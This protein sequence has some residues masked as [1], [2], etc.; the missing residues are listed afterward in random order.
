MGG[1]S[2]LPMNT[3]IPLASALRAS[4]CWYQL[5]RIIGSGLGWPVAFALRY[6]SKTG[7]SMTSQTEDCRAIVVKFVDAIGDGRLDD[8]RSLLHDEFVVH[9]A[10]GVPYSGDYHGHEG[11]FG[12]LTKIYEVLELTPSPDMQYL[13]DDDKV[14][15]V[16]RLTFTARA[17]RESIEMG[18]AEVLSIRDGLIAE[19]DVFYKDPGAVASLLAA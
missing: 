14:V 9:A 5:D 16:Y 11:F 12:L 19:L 15:L 4:A 10:A 6:P 17:S 7:G 13:A 2:A 8:A 18:V 1:V 3:L